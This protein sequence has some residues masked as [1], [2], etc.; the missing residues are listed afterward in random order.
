MSSD[1]ANGIHGSIVR[2]RRAPHI[3][4]EHQ[5]LKFNDL[6]FDLDRGIGVAAAG[7]SEEHDETLNPSFIPRI[8]VRWSDNGGATY[9][10]FLQISAGEQADWKIK[11]TVRKFG[12][13]SDRVTEI[14]VS[15]ARPWRLCAAY[16]RVTPTNDLKE[17]GRMTAGG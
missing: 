9:G 14:R 17:P 7:S 6:E 12:M 4:Q 11:P 10:N 2:M 15:A 3:N 1:T 5:R 13:A 8:R 16:V